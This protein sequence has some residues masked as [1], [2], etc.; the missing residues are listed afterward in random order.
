MNKNKNKK[1]THRGDW[2]HDHQIKSLAL[3]QLS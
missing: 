1:Y 3:Y 2:T